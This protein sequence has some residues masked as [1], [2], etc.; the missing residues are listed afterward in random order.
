MEE[1]FDGNFLVEFQKRGQGLKT[2]ESEEKTEWSGATGSPL[3]SY[4]EPSALALL[5]FVHAT[6]PV[7]NEWNPCTFGS[8]L[9]KRLHRHE[10]N[11][12][13]LAQDA[14]GPGHNLFRE[15]YDSVFCI[16]LFLSMSHLPG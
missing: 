16:M 11:P 10:A 6:L 5:T 2:I 1:I 3:L 15:T 13:P 12:V 7:G 4:E 14:P 8:A 9:L